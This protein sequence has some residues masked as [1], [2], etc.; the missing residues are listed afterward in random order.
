MIIRLDAF[1]VKQLYLQTVSYKSALKGL[2]DDG[3][4]S[5]EGKDKLKEIELL[6]KTIEEY[7]EVY[8]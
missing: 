4:L 3:I 8:R 1:H 5:D 2:L 7:N 6:L